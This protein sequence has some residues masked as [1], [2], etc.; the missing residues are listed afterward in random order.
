MHA[1]SNWGPLSFSISL[2]EA[3]SFS[4]SSVEANICL[5]YFSLNAESDLRS[6]FKFNSMWGEVSRIAK[7]ALGLWCNE[8]KWHPPCLYHP[9]SIITMFV[10][11]LCI[12]HM[13][14]HFSCCDILQDNSLSC[15]QAWHSLLSF[16][17]RKEKELMHLRMH[18][19]WRKYDKSS[20]RPR[21]WILDN[22]LPLQSME[23]MTFW[24]PF[25]LSTCSLAS[26]EDVL[27]A[28]II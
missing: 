8:G 17:D 26:S 4:I 12:R 23:S 2:V 11:F 25:L 16:W 3:L 6:G 14:H 21:W 13:V 20:T 18:L 7:F 22:L 19:R 5:L 15:C 27:S 1:L 24:R 28:A 9:A 10:I